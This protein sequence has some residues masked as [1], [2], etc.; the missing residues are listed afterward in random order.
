[1]IA[2]PGYD[3]CRKHDRK[4]H[5]PMLPGVVLDLIRKTNDSN[6][7]SEKKNEHSNVK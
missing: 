7:I 5:P 6:K 4:M 1:M 3:D 2:T